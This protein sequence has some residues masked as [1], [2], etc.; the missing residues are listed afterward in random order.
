MNLTETTDIDKIKRQFES[1]SDFV[2]QRKQLL[3]QAVVFCYFR[4]FVNL[5][6]TNQLLSWMDSSPISDWQQQISL[7]NGQFIATYDKQMNSLLEGNLV[8]YLL[9]N[10]IRNFVI[11]PVPTM[12]KRAIDVPQ[13]ENVVESSYGAFNE[14][15]DTNMALIRNELR[16]P[17]LTMN[18][19]LMGTKQPKLTTLA[20]LSDSVNHRLLSSLMKKLEA[21]KAK[22]FNHLQEIIKV[23]GEGNFSLISPCLTSE[24]PAEAA[25]HLKNGRVI[26]FIEGL[27]FAFILPVIIT[28][29]WCVKSDRNFPKATMITLRMLRIIGL[30]IA[31]VLPAIYVSLVSVNPEVLRI[32]LALSVAQSREG[33]P[34]PAFLEVIFMLII[35]EMLIE[36]SVR[37]PK[38]IGPSITTVGGIIL[39]QA[40]VSAKLV[41]NL[42][43]IVLAASA[44]ANFTLNGVQNGLFI[45]LSKYVLIVFSAI[46]GV[47]GTI[48]GLIWLSIY[49]ASISTFGVAYIN[50][51]VK[52]GP[53]DG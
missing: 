23:L 35:L 8:I 7:L 6:H 33:V 39:G 37:L 43:I 2:M 44:L 30:F 22:E 15:L 24:R 27:L 48:G 3:G 46:F 31:L 1:N 20:Y 49:M 29:L 5:A 41:S 45:R 18:T 4:P 21:N 50:V 36:A 40:V 12:I 32:Q 10:P 19:L 52:E 28:D 17:T 34:Y 25:D 16:S 9:D 53:Q 26:L 13:N 47:L 42:F 51:N 38:S 14:D 11:K